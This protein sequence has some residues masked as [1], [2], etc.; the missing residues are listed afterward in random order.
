MSIEDRIAALELRELELDQKVSF[1]L[2]NV[3]TK[4]GSSRDVLLQAQA[5]QR[6]LRAS[7][8]SLLTNPEFQRFSGLFSAL[9][10]LQSACTILD[11]IQKWYQLRCSM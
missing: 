6:E 1:L 11:K 7:L 5:R 10:R 8:R 3:Q 4:L 9:Q 2:Q